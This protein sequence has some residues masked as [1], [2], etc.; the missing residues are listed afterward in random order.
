[1]ESSFRDERE[2]AERLGRSVRLA[3]LNDD[4]VQRAKIRMVG[5]A[6]F[7]FRASDARVV[8]DVGGEGDGHGEVGL[9]PAAVFDWCPEVWNM[10][11][12]RVFADVALVV[13]IRE[14]AQE[15]AFAIDWRTARIGD[16]LEFHQHPR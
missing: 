9:G 16:G 11:V 13:E 1:M 10:A 14:R 15:Q 7:I 5:V 3:L 8:A 4:F 12:Y 2:D 6:L